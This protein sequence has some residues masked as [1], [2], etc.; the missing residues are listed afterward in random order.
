MAAAVALA[1]PAMQAYGSYLSGQAQGDALDYQA[2]NATNNAEIAKQQGDFNAART[3]LFANQKIGNEV[4]GYAA[5]GVDTS[6]GSALA[7][8]QAS[9]ANAE[10]DR[11]SILHGADI[12]AI[13]FENQASIDKIAGANTRVASN[14]G[15]AGGA[16]GAGANAYSQS[17]RGPGAQDSTA[18]PEFAS[19]GGS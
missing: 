2:Q 18:D 19:V 1:G 16:I 4:A 13:N 11:L 8:I 15:V 14:W 6:S 5:S 9:H 10:L 3:M 7:V 12:K 17:S